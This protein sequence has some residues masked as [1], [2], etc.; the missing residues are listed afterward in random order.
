MIEIM[1]LEK[2]IVRGDGLGLRRWVELGENLLQS[3]LDRFRA[4]P[5][6]KLC[7]VIPISSQDVGF[8]KRHIKSILILILLQI[9]P[10]STGLLNIK[11]MI[12]PFQFKISIARLDNRK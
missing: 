4:N 5:S 11:L 7:H 1:F 8:G 6:T 10:L 3:T 2:C 12:F 9:L